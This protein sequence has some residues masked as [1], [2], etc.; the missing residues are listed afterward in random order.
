MSTTARTALVNVHWLHQGNL[1]KKKTRKNVELCNCAFLS[2]W[3]TGHCQVFTVTLSHPQLRQTYSVKVWK[4]KQVFVTQFFK[5]NKIYY[6][7]YPAK[8]EWCCWC[9]TYHCFFV[10]FFVIQFNHDRDGGRTRRERMCN[11][12]KKCN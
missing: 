7:V 10:L 1:A 9:A 6:A 12:L 4:K 11:L 8:G 3:L 5:S 2:D